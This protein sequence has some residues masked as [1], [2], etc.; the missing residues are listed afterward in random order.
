MTEPAPRA[1]AEAARLLVA[2]QEWL[3][4]SAPHLAPVDADGEPCSCPLCRAVAA[5]RDADP[6]TVAR[7]VDGAVSAVERV[8]A[9]A[10][11]AA[12]SRTGGGGAEDDPED[13][14]EGED[15]AEHDDAPAE[16]DSAPEARRVRR[17]PIDAEPSGDG[18]HDG[19]DP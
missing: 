3:R 17:I 12:G 14:A 2:A 5:V 19:T 10:A 15:A 8:A 11:A 13:E 18:A 4:G 7:W 1:G 6:D 9:D 16:G